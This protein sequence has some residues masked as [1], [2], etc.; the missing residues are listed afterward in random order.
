MNRRNLLG[1]VVATAAIAVSPNLLW[2]V[3]STV[4]IENRGPSAVSELVLEAC[5]ESLRLGELGPGDSVLRILPRCGDDTFVMSTGTHEG[6][7]LYVEE[8]MYHVRAWI[9]P[10]GE[11]GCDYGGSTPFTPLLLLELIR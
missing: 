9:S 2:L 8:S 7:T 6:C 1:L 11:P 5:S 3:R 10:S 4:R